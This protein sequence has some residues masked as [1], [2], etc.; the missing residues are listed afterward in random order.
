MGGYTSA[1]K[2]LQS[3]PGPH[4]R[5]CVCFVCKVCHVCIVRKSAC[6]IERKR[7]NKNS[8]QTNVVSAGVVGGATVT[9]K[10]DLTDDNG[11][12][13]LHVC[14]QT[15]AVCRPPAPSAAKAHLPQRHVCRRA[16]ASQQKQRHVC[17]LQINVVS[18]DVVG[19]ATVTD[20][21]DLTDNN[22]QWVVTRLQTHVYRQQTSTPHA[23]CIWSVVL[24]NWV[25]SFCRDGLSTI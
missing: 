20:K 13:W 1:N 7:A 24:V 17:R 6:Q 25:F 21:T 16:Q 8:L 18:A 3:A 23:V 22:G 12:G 2:R 11:Q 5:W 14:R 9:D 19:G 10:T 4:R 15:L